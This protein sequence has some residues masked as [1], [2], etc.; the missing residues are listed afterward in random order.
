MDIV[1]VERR[2]PQAKAK[3][4]RRMGIVPCSVYG[5]AL[6]NAV[7][8]QMTQKDANLLFREKRDGSKIRLKLDG[9]VI[10]TQIKEST[11][12]SDNH[13]IEHISF[14]ALKAGQ[15]VNSVAH[16]YRKNADTVRGI[17]EQ[18]IDE[19]PYESLPEYM[20]DAITI[21]LDGA[22]VGTVITIADIP[23]LNNEHITLQIPS[24]SIVLR[25]TD[26]KTVP[27][28]EDAGEGTEEE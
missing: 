4:L 23:E 11:R 10:P 9:K 19:V 20:V 17:L 14:Q 3:H 16:I 27:D 28:E 13:N 22:E 18:M 1:N 2:D 5:G 8:I 7:S 6:P 21:D 15:T 25:I 24:D 12:N 26:T